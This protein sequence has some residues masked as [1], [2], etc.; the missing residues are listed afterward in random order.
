MRN[1]KVGFAVVGCGV[2]GPFHT[3]CIDACDNASLVAVCDIEKDKADKLAAEHGDGV[4]SYA[5]YHEM[6]AKERDADVVCVCTPSG[7]HWE[8]AAAAAGAGRHVLS[9]KPL[10]ITR[11]HMDAMIDGC[12]SAGVKLGGIFQRRTYPASRKVRQMLDEGRLGKLVLC[13]SYQKYYRSPEY[14]RSAGWRGTWELD[15]GGAL[16]NQ[17]VHG[18]DLTQYLV[19]DVASV[20]AYA[21]HLVRDI[22][23]EDTCVA[24]LKFANGAVGTLTGTTSVTP[25]FT[26]RHEIHGE[27]GTILLTDHGIDE[28]YVAADKAG[29]A[30]KLD[31]AEY[32]Y[33]GEDA[34]K[35]ASSDPK[36][37]P[38]K[39][40]AVLIADMA[41]AVAED[42]EPMIPGTEARKAVEV[43]LAI[44]ESARTG[45]EVN[46]KAKG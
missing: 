7:I 18:I 38:S 3:Q 8:V 1:G 36:N 20:Y 12:R 9:E 39:G 22:E 29:K 21:D 32:A 42:R 13:D 33:E 24:V 15:G 5:D 34:E 26:C 27:N 28:V 4:A 45:S 44:Y 40:H 30:E 2:I 43:I 41:A 35:S 19:G 31:P 25:G 10:D 14:Y 11:D 6:L 46:L 17:A 23:V 37:I 16:M